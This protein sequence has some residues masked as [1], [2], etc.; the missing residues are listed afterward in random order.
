MP[1][2]GQEC[3]ILLMRSII[4]KNSPEKSTTVAS[5]SLCSIL[6]PNMQTSSDIDVDPRFEGVH[7]S[8]NTKR[9]HNL[10]AHSEEASAPPRAGVDGKLRARRL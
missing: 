1:N 6:N 7:R 4:E 9:R 10:S 5:P 2:S 3:G 8:P